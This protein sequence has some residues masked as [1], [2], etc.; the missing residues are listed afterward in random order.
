MPRHWKDSQKGDEGANLKFRK[1][2]R[3]PKKCDKSTIKW[4]LTL[5]E[6]I[7]DSHLLEFPEILYHGCKSEVKREEERKKL[8]RKKGKSVEPWS[9][10]SNS[11]YVPKLWPAYVFGCRNGGWWAWTQ[12]P[13][14][15][16]RI[17]NKVIWETHLLIY[18]GM[19]S[20]LQVDGAGEEKI[21]ERWCHT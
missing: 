10:F 8:E 9:E 20:P 21:G 11:Y 12:L 18:P 13:K 7:E 2:H 15:P 14:S 4:V 5:E 16:L 19:S 1:Q 17:D 3:I 6:H